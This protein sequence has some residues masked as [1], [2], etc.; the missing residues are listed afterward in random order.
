MKAQILKVVLRLSVSKRSAVAIALCGLMG[1]VSYL[2]I[3]QEQNGFEEALQGAPLIGVIG[4][5]QNPLQIALLHWYNANST[6]T[7]G[8]GG[9]PPRRGL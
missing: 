8:V 7:F 9:S 1:V 2:A 5:T 4:S 6:T 3:T